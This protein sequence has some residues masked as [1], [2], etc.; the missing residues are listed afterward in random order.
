VD[1]GLVGTIPDLYRMTKEQLLELERMGELSTK[2]L[3]DGIE[4][5]KGRGLARVLTGLGI[6]HVGETVGELLAWEFG[7][8]DA[9]VAAFE[10]RL[11]QVEG[12]GPERARTIHEYLHSPGGQKTL[13]ELKAEGVKMTEAPRPKPAAGG[14]DLTGKTLV[15]TGTLPTYSRED[16]EDLI[17]KLGGK[18]AGSVSKKTAYVVAG[19]KAGSKLE[20]ARQ[21]GVPVLTEAE[22]DKLIGKK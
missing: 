1:S 21:L 4:A 17:K 12:I 11:A 9:L 7:D 10:E 20:K 22:F 14:A 15:V 5:S 19:E 3:L 16:I 18:V 8:I 6:R 2:N 13:A